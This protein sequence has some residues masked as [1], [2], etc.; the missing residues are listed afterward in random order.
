MASDTQSSQRWEKGALLVGFV[1]LAAAV[2]VAHGSPPEAYEL[3]IYAGTPPAFWLGTAAALLVA[4]FVGL[5]ASG[6]TRR[7]ALVLGGTAMLAVA[8]LPVLRSYY[9]FGAGDS[10]THL[11]WAKDIASGKLAVVDLL[12]PGTHT[13]AV[14]LADATGMELTR[15]MLVMV[16]AFTA[17]FLLFLPLATWAITRDRRATTVAA[18][19]GLLFMPVNNVSVF[20]MPHPTTQAIMFLP[21]VLYLSARYLT[22]A[23]RDGL[24][25]GTPT[26]ALLALASVAVVLVHPQQAA[27]VLVVFVAIVGLQLVARYLGGE[28]TDHRT[29]ALQAVFLAG[30]FAVWTPRHERASGASSALVN[31][32]MSGLQLGTE[33]TQAAGSV[34][35]V[36]GS[37]QMLFLKLFAVSV[38]FCALA[39]L[40]V[41][42]GVLGRIEESNLTAFSRYFGFALVPLFGLF[43]AYFIV[44]YEKLHFRQLGFIMV[45]VTI[46]GA[47]ALAR[48]MDLLSTRFSLSPASARTLVGV[49]LVVMLAATVP[50]VYQSPYMYQSSSHVTEAQMTGYANAIEHR[51]SAPFV[52]IRGTGERWTDGVLGYEESRERKLGAASLYASE[53]HPAVGEN[54]TGSYI[55]RHYD[56]RYLT[57]TD[58]VRQQELQVYDGFRF[59][60]AGF[61]SLD[62]TPGLNRVQANGGFQMYQ[63][64]E[65]S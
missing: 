22:R 23:D 53:T 38:V 19:S 1:S 17:T 11:G 3:S 52:G 55:T 10:L 42:G 5:R 25:V 9:F 59:G 24:A 31:M 45:L 6:G 58:R 61:R 47:V 60:A 18:L 13:I 44:S 57:F 29:F 16:M 8:S 41:L 26:G 62:A 35:S 43:A 15:A 49:V 34:A 46:L 14:M 50:T 20:D 7:L 4:V 28:A 2:L 30:V 64:N 33:T 65:T 40:L 39:G 27:N 32:L 21:L 56:D 37:L 48:G 54:F 36:G 63:I 12:Y 51:G